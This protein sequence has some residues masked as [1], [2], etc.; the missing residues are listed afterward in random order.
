VAIGAINPN[1]TAVAQQPVL[2]QNRSVDRSNFLPTLAESELP[3]AVGEYLTLQHPTLLL[4]G[5][6][7]FN[8]GHFLVDELPGVVAYV[9]KF[10]PAVL[11]VAMAPTTWAIHSNRYG[12]SLR[13]MRQIVAEF[14]HLRFG[15]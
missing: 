14:F 2:E 3:T 15:R 10:K 12:D 8:W 11:A 13:T 4:I 6:G 9:S 7:S 1:G 5:A